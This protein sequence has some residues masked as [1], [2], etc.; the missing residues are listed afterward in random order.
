M[1]PTNMAI[2]IIFMVACTAFNYLGYTKGILVLQLF[3]FL[4]CSM[5]GIWAWNEN[6]DTWFLPTLFIVANLLLFTWPLIRRD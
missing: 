5:G 4:M 1:D 2:A 6:P 3:S